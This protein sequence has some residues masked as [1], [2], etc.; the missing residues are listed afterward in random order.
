MD[1][2]LF[3]E[4]LSQIAD[5]YIPIVKENS[6]QSY[7][8]KPMP[9]SELNPTMGPVI[10][11]LKPCLNACAWCQK[12]V[13]QRTTHKRVFNYKGRFTH[14]SHECQTCRS[15]YDPLT[16]KVVK[17]GVGDKKPKAVAAKKTYWWNEGI[18]VSGKK[19]G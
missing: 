11:Q 8:R 15:V 19:L 13:D 18:D 4:K 14:W 5:W 12:I 3:N 7:N 9:G 10:D 16:G 1:R 17:K 2:K 6:R